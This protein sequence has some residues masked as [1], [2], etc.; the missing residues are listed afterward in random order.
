[1]RNHI[2]SATAFYFA[3]TEALFA[4]SGLGGGGLGKQLQEFAMSETMLSAIEMREVIRSADIR[5]ETETL[6]MSRRTSIGME[7]D[8]DQP[9]GVLIEVKASDFSEIAADALIGKDFIYRDITVR[10]TES[11]TENEIVTMSPIEDS[12]VTIVVKAVEGS[13]L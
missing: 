9:A 5:P 10:V 8:I 1:M 3:I 13:S 12:S 11:D 6:R 2:L 7:S 4:G